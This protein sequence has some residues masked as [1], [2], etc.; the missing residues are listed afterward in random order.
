MQQAFNYFN[1]Q[2]RPI[3]ALVEP[4]PLLAT[5]LIQSESRVLRSATCHIAV[6]ATTHFDEL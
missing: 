4:A 6:D 3:L 1:I 5:H 2:A